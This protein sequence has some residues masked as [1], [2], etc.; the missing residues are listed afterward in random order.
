MSR[1]GDFLVQ[2]QA[3]QLGDREYVEFPIEGTTQ[4]STFLPDREEASSLEREVRESLTSLCNGDEQLALDVRD[5][6][7]FMF[8]DDRDLW[9][10]SSEDQ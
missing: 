6:F 1:L 9:P 8:F 10:V 3:Y 2:L 4:T 5:Y 7:L